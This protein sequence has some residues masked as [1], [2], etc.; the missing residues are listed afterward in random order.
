ME[1]PRPSR[2]EARRAMIR[3]N[4]AFL[5]E[6]IHNLVAAPDPYVVKLWA[7]LLDEFGLTKE[8]LKRI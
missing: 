4:D 7:W 8:D 3:T 2:E 6:G 5:F 1:A